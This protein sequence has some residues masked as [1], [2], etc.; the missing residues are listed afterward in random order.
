MFL[1]FFVFSCEILHSLP[2]K[3]IPAVRVWAFVTTVPGGFLLPQSRGQEIPNGGTDMASEAERNR[4]SP[5]RIHPIRLLVTPEAFTGI[6]REVVP[7]DGRGRGLAHRCSLFHQPLF[8]WPLTHCPHHKYVIHTRLVAHPCPPVACTAT[9]G[10]CEVVWIDANGGIEVHAVGFPV[11]FHRCMAPA[12][13]ECNFSHAG[14]DPRDIEGPGT[15]LAHPRGHVGPQRGPGNGSWRPEGEGRHR[16]ADPGVP[17]PHTGPPLQTP[18]PPLI[19]YPTSSVPHLVTSHLCERGKCAFREF[20]DRGY[21]QAHS[22][23]R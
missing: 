4:R 22:R 1:L 15:H 17:N 16:A 12:A 2:G 7:L 14:G 19:I 9:C 6:V 18:H 11:A 5:C 8:S 21:L 23:S 13:P 20:C 10:R 3:G